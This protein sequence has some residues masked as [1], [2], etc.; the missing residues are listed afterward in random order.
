MATSDR[1]PADTVTVAEVHDLAVALYDRYE[2]LAEVKAYYGVLAIYA[3]ARTGA[4]AGDG[5]ILDRVER[6][7]DRFPD[8]IDHPP[9]NFPSY[10][11]GGIAQ[12]FMIAQGRMTHRREL[13]RDYADEMMAAPRDARGIL[14]MINQP[15]DRIW[16]D[17]AMAAT[18][19]LL[20]AGQALDRP[21]YVDESINQTVLMYDEF[22]DHDL[23]LLHQCKNFIAPGVTSTDH[24]G[25]G[26]GWGIFALAELVRGL[27]ADAP[28]RGEVERRFV[29]LAESLL[30]YQ[31]ERGLWRQ[32]IPM[33]EAWEESSGTGLIVY[34]LGVGVRSGLLAGDRWIDAVRTGLIGLARH[35][36]NPDFSTENSCPGTLCPGSGAERGTPE[37]YVRLRVPVRDEP[38]SYAALM[39]ALNVADCC[40]ITELELRSV[41]QQTPYLTGPE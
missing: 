37:A 24:W 27:P 21:D 31:S 5:P 7:L 3:L 33:A 12:S 41:P 8:R 28:R 9:Y 10:R 2:S 29:A 22:L 4:D 20:S 17:V 1:R 35:C 19:F 16:I 26:N 13:L 23:G 15:D 38:H 25:R 39:L 40:G 30:P 11:I 6:I 36:I 14:T 18:P 32:E 34:G